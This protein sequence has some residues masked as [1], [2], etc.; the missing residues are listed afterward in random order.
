MGGLEC[1]LVL[2]NDMVSVADWRALCPAALKQVP[3]VCYFH[4]NQ[5]SYPLQNE[6]DRD[7]QYG[8]TNIT[9]CLASDAIWFNSAYHRDEFCQGADRLMKMMPD[10][11]PEGIVGDILAKSKVMHPGIGPPIASSEEASDLHRDGPT[12]ILWNHRWEYDKNPEAFFEAMVKLDNVGAEFD[13]YVA[14]ERFRT[15]PAIF[16]E[17]K[18]HLSG[19]IRHWGYARTREDYQRILERCDCVISTAIHEFFGLSVLEAVSAGCLAILPQQLSYP[20][21]FGAAAP[22]VAVFYGKDRDLVEVLSE[23]IV[24]KDRTGQDRRRSIGFAERYRWSKRVDEYDA[25]FDAV[26]VHR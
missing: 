20:E 19:R 23:C 1:D 21:L 25:G 8:F 13:L 16:E 5:I 24:R 2:A 18:Q 4:E 10:H 15:E 11:V 26:A 9:T 14:G 7:Y 6:A 17:A 22:T 12:A 3:V